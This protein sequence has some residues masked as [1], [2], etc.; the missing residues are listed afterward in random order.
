MGTPFGTPF[1]T[2]E[3]GDNLVDDPNFDAFVT[4]S[5]VVNDGEDQPLSPKPPTSGYNLDFLDNLDDPN[6]NPFETKASVV[7]DGEP[8][9][10]AAVSK[11][12]DNSN[13]KKMSQ[14]QTAF[15]LRKKIKSDAARKS[16][17]T[18]STNTEVTA[19]PVSTSSQSNAAAATSA[20]A[21]ET[22]V[23]VSCLNNS[24]S[25]SPE[26]PAVIKDTF[27]VLELNV[28]SLNKQPDDNSVVEN[29]V[30]TL[31]EAMKDLPIA[32][33]KPTAIVKPN[34]EM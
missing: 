9:P 34:S 31:N 25:S 21:A 19:H 2:P 32:S 24:S 7:N 13:A 4:K 22:S 11:A 6:F 33:S 29:V 26:Q 5:H 8:L 10:V 30:E 18:S 20:A 12:V 1:Q 3:K 14:V 23:S 16:H 27:D 17:D 28:A 15:A